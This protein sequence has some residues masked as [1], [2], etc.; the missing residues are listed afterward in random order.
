LA[1]KLPDKTK[2][3]FILIRKEFPSEFVEKMKYPVDR[4]HIHHSV[5]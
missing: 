2:T 3:R 4:N 5:G 1:G